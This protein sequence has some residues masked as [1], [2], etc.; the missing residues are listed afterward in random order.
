MSLKIL[1]LSDV[2]LD[3]LFNPQVRE[4]FRDV[5]LIISCGDLPGYYLEYVVNSLDAWLYFVR[6]NH[7]VIVE[8]TESGSR[9]ASF[10]GV[11]LHRRTNRFDD[12]LLAG[13]EGSLRYR[14]GPFQYSQSEMWG[15]VFSL[16]PSFLLNRVRYGRFLDVFITHAPPMGIHDQTDLPHRGIA[17]FRWLLQVFKPTYHFHGHVH[18][19]RPDAERVTRFGETRVVNTYGFAETVIP[20]RS[21][22]NQ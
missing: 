11:N 13:V 19:Y 5:Q 1:S 10:G 14:E 15:H 22:T 2:V 16:V 18:L 12:L 9:Q 4:R 6:G 20:P 8:E 3:V 17:A 7:D 21:A